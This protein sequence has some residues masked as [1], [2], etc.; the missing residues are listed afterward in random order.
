MFQ[1]LAKRISLQ[2]LKYSI[3]ADQFLCDTARN[4]NPG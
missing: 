1:K 3:V 4:A 2:T